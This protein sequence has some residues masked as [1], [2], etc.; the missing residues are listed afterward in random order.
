MVDGSHVLYHY[1]QKDLL[2]SDIWLFQMLASRLIVSL[3]IWLPPSLYAQLPILVPYAVRD[4]GCRGDSRKGIVDQWGSPNAGGFFRD[5]N[6]LIKSIPRSLTISQSANSLYRGAGVGKGFV[7]SHVWREIRGEIE[8]AARDPLTYSF[9]PNVVWL[10]AQVAKLT[11]REGSFV[12][13]YLQA[14]SYKIYRKHPVAP[15]LQGLVDDV[16]SRLPLSHRIPVQGL[17]GIEDLNFFDSSNEFVARRRASLAAVRD[18]A[19]ILLQGGR[20]SRKIISSRFTEGLPSVGVDELTSLSRLL[21][22][23]LLGGPTP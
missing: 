18:A 20:L 21:S 11:D 16:W 14:I 8:L 17:P 19:D 10:P 15:P 7:A 12:Q 13:E 9:V 6:S 22:R 5:D 23:L 3:G 1:L 2:S 4:P